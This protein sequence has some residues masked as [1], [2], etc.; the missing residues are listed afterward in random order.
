MTDKSLQND[1][2]AFPAPDSSTDGAPVAEQHVIAANPPFAN[3][4]HLP[5]LVYRKGV[6][7]D[8]D[9]PG[10]AMEDHFQRNGWGYSWRNGIFNYHHFHSTAHEV[11]GVAAGTATV[12]L[13]GPG[14]P[15][16]EMQAGDVIVIPVGVA[17][18]N[19]GSS[20]DLIAVGAYPPGQ[21]WDLN[22]GD[23]GEHPRVDRNIEHVALPTTDPVLGP[24]GPLLTHW[25]IAP[26]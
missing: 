18:R 23:A 24:D 10:S 7:L 21:V 16:V 19:I 5:V 22:T 1:P 15:R 13:G 4:P 8:G 25:G 12:E 2:F 20:P 17:L 3:N 6:V 11:L 9:D 26:A 14:G